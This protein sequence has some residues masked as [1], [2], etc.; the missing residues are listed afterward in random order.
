MLEAEASSE[1]G[2]MQTSTLISV[3]GRASP[4]RVG[5]PLNWLG[6]M[7]MRRTSLTIAMLLATA[8]PAF[9]QDW[10]K[11]FEAVQNKNYEVALRELVPLANSGNSRA[12]MMLGHLHERGLGVEKNNTEAAK[13]YLKAAENG[14]V[15]SQA[16]IG[17]MYL[18]GIGITKDYDQAMKWFQSAVSNGDLRSMVLIGL[19]HDEGRSVPIDWAKAASW[20]RKAATK[21]YASAQNLLGFA[22]ANGRGVSQNNLWAYVWFTLASDNGQRQADE[23]VASIERMMSNDEIAKAHEIAKNCLDTGYRGCE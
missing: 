1:T 21:G 10:A 15:I 3:T 14:D 5:P 6:T 22:Y 23:D 9:A 17:S 7:K 11:G 20:Y 4:L 18:N 16:S 8:A 19:M 13:W 12:Q 2:G